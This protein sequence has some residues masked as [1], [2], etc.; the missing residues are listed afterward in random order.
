MIDNLREEYQNLIKKGYNLTEVGNQLRASI[1]LMQ[2]QVPLVREQ[3]FKTEM[4]GFLAK[5]DKEA[6]ESFGNLG[7]EA[8]Q[9]KPLFDILRMFIRR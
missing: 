6:A 5:L 7:R 2:A 3:T 8:Q 4:E 1:S 9:F